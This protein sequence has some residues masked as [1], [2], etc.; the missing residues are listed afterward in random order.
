MNQEFKGNSSIYNTGNIGQ[1]HSKDE[2]R[3]L[4]NTRNEINLYKLKI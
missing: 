2:T 4:S 1:S 3:S